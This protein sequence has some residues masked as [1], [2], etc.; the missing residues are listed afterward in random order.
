MHCIIALNLYLIIITADHLKN[1][2]FRIK[3]HTKTIKYI[4]LEKYN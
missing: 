4:S 2:T 3:T 1:A